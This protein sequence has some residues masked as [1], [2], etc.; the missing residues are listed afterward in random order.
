MSKP[1]VAIHKFASCS[2]CQLAFV[3]MG[4]ELVELTKLVEIVHM[5]E[6]GHVA[7]ESENV[8]IAFVEGSITTPH[9]VERLLKIREHSKY[10]ITMGACATSGG[11]QA[12]RNH[13]DAA[14]WMRSVYAKPEYI[15]SLSTSA[16][17]ANHVKVDFELWGCPVSVRQMLA[18]IRSF[19]FG[20]PPQILREKVCQECKRR[21]NN[22]ILITQGAAC[23]GPVT[24][25][26]CGALCPTFGAPCYTCYGPAEGT[27]TASFGQRLMGLGLNADQVARKFASIN[28]AA[29]VFSEATEMFATKTWME[30]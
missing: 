9:D 10:L 5:A 8:D 13:A 26:G 18:A 20:V 4:I 2:G 19:L 6:V 11:I 12:L 22:C 24:R 30:E 3:N 23:M 7:P 1:R 28:N 29:P 25:T 15:Q 17:I 21:G 14:E 16:A 27:N